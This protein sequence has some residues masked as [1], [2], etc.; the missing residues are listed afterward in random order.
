MPEKVGPGLSDFDR[1]ICAWWSKIRPDAEGG[2]PLTCRSIYIF[3]GQIW[4][5][6]DSASPRAVELNHQFY[7]AKSNC[8]FSEIKMPRIL[9]P[10]LYILLSFSQLAFSHLAFVMVRQNARSVWM[11]EW[12]DGHTDL[13][14]NEAS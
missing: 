1:T 7:F 6:A 12:Q 8:L 9:A 14:R 5:D 2:G 4:V 13:G 3:G 10:S 11:N